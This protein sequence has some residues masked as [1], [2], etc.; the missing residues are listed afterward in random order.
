MFKWLKRRKDVKKLKALKKEITEAV[1][2]LEVV[3]DKTIIGELTDTRNP[4]GP[5]Q[6]DKVNITQ[7]IMSLYAVM[8]EMDK[9]IDDRTRERPPICKERVK[10]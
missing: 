6:L 4:G 2:S 3:R 5:V 10:E 1:A 9:E 7:L 8:D